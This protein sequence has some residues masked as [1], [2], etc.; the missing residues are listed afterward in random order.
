MH[1]HM[2][3]ESTHKTLQFFLWNKLIENRNHSKNKQQQ[4]PGIVEHACNLSQISEFKTS[5]VDIVSSLRLCLQKRGCK[6]IQRLLCMPLDSPNLTYLSICSILIF[7][8]SF[9]GYFYLSWNRQKY[10][11]LWYTACVDIYI[12][13]TKTSYLT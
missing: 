10:V 8:I 5:L 11:H 9:L 1:L 13:N 4:Q 3:D 12:E 2:G 6:I 7:P